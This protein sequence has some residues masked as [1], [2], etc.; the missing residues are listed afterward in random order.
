MSYHSQQYLNSGNILV[1][2][3]QN[4][5]PAWWYDASLENAAAPTHFQDFIPLPVV[6]DRLFGW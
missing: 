4:S 3:V 6:R 1:G 2:N 5:R